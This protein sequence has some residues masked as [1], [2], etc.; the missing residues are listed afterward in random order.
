MTFKF[1]ILIFLF[2]SA[3]P[4]E[5]ASHWKN[6]LEYK[7]PD[8]LDPKLQE[9]KKKGF[10]IQHLTEADGKLVN[11]DYFPVTVR[12]L[13]KNPK[14]GVQYSAEEF[15]SYIRLNFNSFI[16]QKYASFSPSKRLGA[17]EEKRW[18]SDNPVGAVI[19]INIPF[20]AGDGSVICTEF[21][22]DHWVYS[23]I[24]TPWRFFG[25]GNDGLHPVSGFRQTGFTKNENG[26]YTFYTKGVD[27]M[28][29]KSQAIVAETLMKN[30]FKEADKLW[31]SFRQ[32]IFDFVQQNGGN[33][34]PLDSTKVE[35]YHFKWKEVKACK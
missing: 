2:L 12:I 35:T 32:G 21:T 15:L 9:L 11:L 16:N 20:P 26:T 8:S 28:S 23:T 18:L 5:E 1:C 22:S 25:Q 3:S 29:R 6:L 13:P 33:A 24:Q 4:C 19:H 34:V 31:Q 14:T 10:K 27:R 7:I 30:P 17:E